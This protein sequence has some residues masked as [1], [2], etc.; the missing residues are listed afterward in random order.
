MYIGITC[1]WWLAD[2]GVGTDVGTWRHV[3]ATWGPDGFE[4]Y[5]GGQLLGTYPR[6]DAMLNYQVDLIGSRS[7]NGGMTGLIDEV[8]FWAVQRD[9]AEIQSTME[10]PLTPDEYG[11]ADVL[12]YY[13]LD[14]FEDLGVNGDGADDLR[15]LSPNAH[16]AD[17]EGEVSLEGGAVPVGNISWGAVKATFRPE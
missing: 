9:E 8:R 5:V 16:H 11:S 12:A 6:T 17:A 10:R 2:S 13:P 7:G 14:A 15:D 1:C 4:V 3:A